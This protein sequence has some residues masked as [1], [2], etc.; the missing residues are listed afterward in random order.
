MNRTFKNLHDFRKD[1]PSEIWTEEDLIVIEV[2]DLEVLNAICEDFDII[3]VD[4]HSNQIN[5]WPD[6]MNNVLVMYKPE[7]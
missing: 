3:S 5:V 2:N 4:I 6:N 7:E 1:Y